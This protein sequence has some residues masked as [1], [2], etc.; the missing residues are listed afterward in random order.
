MHAVLWVDGI[1]KHILTPRHERMRFSMADELVV[2]GDDLYMLTFECYEFD[3][4]N[5]ETDFDIDILIWM[6]DRVIAKYNG[7]DIVNFTVV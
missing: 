6:N 3:Q 7:I 2:Y 4:P 1:P 5:G